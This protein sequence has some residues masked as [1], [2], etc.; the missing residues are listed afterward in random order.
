MRIHRSSSLLGITCLLASAGALATEDLSKA[1]QSWPMDARK[2]LDM[3][4]QKYGQPDEVTSERV[5]WNDNGPW[6]RT[7]IT[8][9]EAQHA[10]P[11]PHKDVLEQVIDYRV[12]PEKFDELAMYDGSVIA[13]RT[14]GE[15]SARC[16]MEEANFLALNLAHDVVTGAKSVD[17]AREYYARAIMDLKMGK[18]D[19]Y[20]QKLQFSP[21][22]RTADADRPA[23]MRQAME[24]PKG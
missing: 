10:F 11:A 5:V 20:V 1:T 18:K 8:K 16:D 9:E 2:A 21:Q 17:Q 23:P 12:P 3:T 15:L 7:I 6:K 22:Q 14:K 13:E 24:K 19:P 4:V